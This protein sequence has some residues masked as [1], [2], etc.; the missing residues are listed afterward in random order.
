MIVK[1]SEIVGGM[2][3]A[4]REVEAGLHGESE[5]VA[6]YKRHLAAKIERILGQ[7]GPEMDIPSCV[8]LAHLG[9]ECCPVCHET[10]R[11]R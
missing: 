10:T 9:E 2:R 11:M 4:L 5:E 3:Q 7:I 1:R 6:A 8:D